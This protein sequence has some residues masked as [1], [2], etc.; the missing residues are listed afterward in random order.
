VGEEA[1]FSSR[2]LQKFLLDIHD[3]PFSE[4]KKLLLERLDNWRAPAG[5]K[6]IPQTDDMILVGFRI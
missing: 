4:Q 3:R 5:K 6:S 2:R 1:K